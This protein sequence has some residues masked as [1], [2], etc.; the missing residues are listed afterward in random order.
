MKNTTKRILAAAMCA[1]MVLTAAP[2]NGFTN[3]DLPN[4]F[5]FKAEATEEFRPCPYGGIIR[6]DVT[7]EEI[8]LCK[9]SN[10]YHC[11]YNLDLDTGEVIV[12]QYGV[13][14]EDVSQPDSI[15]IPSIY[16]GYPVTRIDPYVF[17]GAN[18]ESISLPNSITTIGKSAFSDSKLESISIP[19]S[20]TKIGVAAFR[21][22]KLTSISIPGSVST[23]E[24]Q[25]FYYCSNLKGVTIGNGVNIIGDSAFI[26]CSSL[27]SV[28]IPNSVR[29]IGNDAFNNCHNLKGVTIGNGVTDIGMQAF[30]NCYA[31]T[32]IAIPDSV[33]SLGEKAFA[34]CSSLES[35]AIGNGIK[36]ISNYTFMNCSK[37]ADVNFGENLTTIGQGAFYYCQA[38]NNVTLPDSLTTIGETAFY[39]CSSLTDIN[40][41]YGVT[42]IGK[43]A[44]SFC[45]KL[46]NVTMPDSVTTIGEGAFTF[47][48]ALKS[49]TIPASVT[50]I[51]NKAFAHCQNLELITVDKNNENYLSD[52]GILFTKD[53]TRLIQ[54]PTGSKRTNYAVPE[55]VTTIDNSAFST[56]NLEYIHIPE[57]VTSIGSIGLADNAYIC[58]TSEDGYIKDYAESNNITYVV[59]HHGEHTHTPVTTT[60]PPTCTTEGT[61]HVVCEECGAT[62]GEKSIPAKG[63]TAGNWTVEVL[64]TCTENGTKIKKCVDCGEIQ[65]SEPIVATGHN[66]GEWVISVEPTCT[67]EG[68]KIAH[69]TECGV[70]VANE[71]VPAAGHTAGEIVATVPATCTE[72]GEGTVSCVVCGEILETVEIPAT[73]HTAGAWETV[74]EPTTET[75]GKKIKKCTVCGVTLEEAAIAKLPKEPVKDNAVVKYPSTT[76]IS[77]GDAIILHV[78]ESKIP[79]GGRVEWT[80]SNNN[81]SYKANG[82]TCTVSP[83]K[84]GDTTFTA[85][86][87]DAEGNPVSTD[88]QSMTSKAGFFQKIIAF[89]KGLFG[90]N[91]TI[92]EVFKF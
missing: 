82:V 55:G 64:A 29:T 14:N 33:K 10:V 73:G 71:V 17:R 75:E 77:Y 7:G 81:F 6:D 23:I 67:E 89:F 91:K 3:S 16:C 70:V 9:E 68:E 65:Q 40:I 15:I 56:R 8:N 59:C 35:V 22:T 37:L 38:L 78:D 51:G 41:P 30:C 11:H 39:N 4:L 2:L 88:E 83:E 79:E 18:F 45:A 90:L 80:A 74:L 92:P 43:S 36:D 47:C 21:N 52:G 50:S 53:K 44:F 27:T 84:S 86:I 54:Y 58:S 66:Q 46:V 20:V 12:A 42:T 32:N 31:L 26:G 1:L 24:P 87:Y 5:S 61:E 63:H 85:T 13:V 62:L 48:N 76:T 28:V 49:V 57:S 60:I 72:K 69:C 34:S 19:S 25:T